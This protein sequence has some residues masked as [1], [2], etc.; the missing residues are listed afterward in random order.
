[1]VTLHLNSNW[2]GFKDQYYSQMKTLGLESGV[3]VLYDSH[4]IQV[5]KFQ[6]KSK[7]SM[8]KTSQ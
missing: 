6:A 7:E 1:M 5:M 2:L 8:Q 3:L 4:A